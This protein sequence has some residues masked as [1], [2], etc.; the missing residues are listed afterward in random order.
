MVNL[1]AFKLYDIRGKYPEEINEKLAYKIGRATVLFFKSKSIIVGRDCRLSSP[2]LSKALIQ[3]IMDQGCDVIDIGLCSTPMIYF[4]SFKE[5]A[6]MIT[7]SHNTKEYNGFKICRKGAQALTYN[8]GLNK[9]K[10]LVNKN[11]FP[12]TKKGRV[13]KKSVLKEYIDFIREFRKN[14]S[15]LKIVIDA[16]N[17]MAGFV[18][19]HLFKSLPVELIPMHFELDGRFPNHDP[20]PFH[21]ENT[22]E[23]QIKVMKE[24]ADL[25]IAYD[26][27]CDRVFFID[28]KGQRVSAE[29]SLLL[30]AKNFVKKNQ[31]VIYSNNCSQIVPETL[32]KMKI[33][34]IISS[35]GHS[36]VKKAMKENQAVLGGEITGHFYFKKNNFADN[37][38]IAVMLMLN[39][40]SNKK[41]PLSE[42]VEAY[43]KYFAS[44]EIEIKT[45]DPKNLMKNVELYYTNKT[46][47]ISHF[48]GLTIK[49][50]DWWF[51]LRES[52]TT[53]VI[54]LI[55]E[56]K[57]K[58][59]L[60]NKINELKSI[61]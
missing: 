18:A 2:S 1:E 31:K 14:I 34:S 48:Y 24:K 11:K 4:A 20:N 47:K 51:I 50:K 17:G 40:V 56:A 59:L 46:E 10:M 5:N 15:N 32:K 57:S 16:G 35:M 30:L 22:E 60:D 49:L 23:L 38:D 26:G 12:K 13:L 25:G 7:A 61:I 43:R 45:K 28:E 41:K 55:V 37:G 42:L 27:D 21:S 9:I 39:I 36:M 52:Q 33:H 6:V 53:N 54:K 19:P 58:E 44:E 29:F 8:S 3:G